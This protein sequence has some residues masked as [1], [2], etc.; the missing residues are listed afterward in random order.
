M[1]NRIVAF[2]SCIG[3][4]SLLFTLAGCEAA[5]ERRLPQLVVVEIAQMQF[6]PAEVSVMEGDTI[7]FI[8]RDMVPHDVTEQT[9]KAWSS[10]PLQPQQSWKHVAE[11]SD[12]YYCSL[13]QVMKGKILVK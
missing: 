11:H 1:K 5:N 2:A 8:N 3:L 7:L 6:K 10:A 4:C 13:H 9:A 12:D